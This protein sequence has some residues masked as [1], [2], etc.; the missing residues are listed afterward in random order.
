MSDSEGHIRSDSVSV[1]DSED[2]ELSENYQEVTHPWQ[3]I[4]ELSG[5]E[6][7]SSSE[8]STS[9]DDSDDWISDLSR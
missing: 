6:S 5:T 9:S 8:H 7:N 4:F 2:G 1:A 3:F